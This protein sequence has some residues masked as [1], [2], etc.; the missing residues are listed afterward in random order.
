MNGKQKIGHRIRRNLDFS[1]LKEL[2]MNASK[3]GLIVLI[4]L[5]IKYMKHI[6]VLRCLL[7]LMR[8]RTTNKTDMSILL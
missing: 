6:V 3:R 4:Y 1:R 8:R 2:I 7:F 5:K